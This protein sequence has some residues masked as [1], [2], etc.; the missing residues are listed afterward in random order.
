MAK[1]TQRS[2]AGTRE[3]Q[4]QVTCSI[5]PKLS[6]ETGL[7]PGYLHCHCKVHPGDKG[8]VTWVWGAPMEPAAGAVLGAG[9]APT[10]LRKT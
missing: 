3:I 7:E 10:E 9:T 1:S 6:Q 8:T 2:Q 5:G 4:R